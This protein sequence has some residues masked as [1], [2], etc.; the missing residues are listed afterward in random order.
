MIN[1]IRDIRKQKGLTLA[2]V[3]A[4]CTPPT[5]AQT[6]GR[7]E[8][9]TRTLSLDWMNRIATALDVDAEV[10]VRSNA[11]PAPRII[12]QLTPAGA[13]PL[14]SPRDAI[15]PSDIGG[16]APLVVICHHGV[17]SYQVAAYLLNAGFAEVF[18]LAGGVAAWA[19]QVDPAMPRY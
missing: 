14:A 15:L 12:A 13:E 16:D 17:R 8:T 11:A 4:A 18:S 9:G 10:L 1:R 3:A 5:T 6:I 2:D 7:L 19:D